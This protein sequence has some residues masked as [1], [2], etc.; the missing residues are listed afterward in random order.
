M[1]NAEPRYLRM[2][3][4]VVLTM[5]LRLRATGVMTDGEV[6][7]NARLGSGHLKGRMARLE[8]LERMANALGFGMHEQVSALDCL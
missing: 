6:I 1:R 3:E 7:L 2:S 5:F 8:L 4:D